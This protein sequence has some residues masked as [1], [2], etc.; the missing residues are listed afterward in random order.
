MIELTNAKCAICGKDYYICMSCKNRIRLKPWT[1]YTDTPECYKVFQIIHG[2]STGV[3]TKEEAKEKL[4][5]IESIELESYKEEIKKVIE[6][7][8][9]DETIKKNKKKNFDEEI[10]VSDDLVEVTNTQKTVA[11]KKTVKKK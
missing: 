3:Y 9:F 6:D 4:Q 11:K 7:I 2:F 8:L 1:V 5:N 10:K